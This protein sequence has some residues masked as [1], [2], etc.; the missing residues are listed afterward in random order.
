MTIRNH[1]SSSQPSFSLLSTAKVSKRSGKS[2]SLEPQRLPQQLPQGGEPPGMWMSWWTSDRNPA[3]SCQLDVENLAIFWNK[4]EGSV[5]RVS[6]W[7][8]AI[9]SLFHSK[10]PRHSKNV[11]FW[12]NFSGAT[13]PVLDTSKVLGRKAG[14]GQDQGIDWMDVEFY[15]LD[16]TFHFWIQMENSNLQLLSLSWVPK[17]LT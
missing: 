11:L 5:R 10:P 17:I 8:M 15:F 13:Y 3:G 12:L 9:G 6:C 14:L 2:V 4:N 1:G 16:V 7:K